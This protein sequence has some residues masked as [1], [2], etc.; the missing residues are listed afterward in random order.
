[1]SDAPRILPIACPFGKGSVV[2]VYYVDAPKPALVDTGVAA[3]PLHV[4]EPALAAAGLRLA[5]VKY[6]LA[7]HGH[8]DHVGG[9]YAAKQVAEAELA[10]HSADVGWL[11]N[12]RA[13]MEYMGLRFTY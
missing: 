4:I 11:R 2:Y 1:M 13:H 6:I 10:L 5:D 3:S 9:A 7:T 12:K 8:W